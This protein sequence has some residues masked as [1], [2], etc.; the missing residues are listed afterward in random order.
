MHR[1]I[2][3]NTL[4]LAP[5]PFGD[6]VQA[7]A[8]IGA[9]GISPDLEQVKEAGI[10]RAG[11]AIRDAGLEVA[12]LTHRAFGFAT[13]GETTAARQ[14]L[15][16]TI[17]IA[18]EIG[19]QSIIMT[20]GGRGV[21]D[22]T[23]A[24]DRF[25]EA[26]APCAEAARVAGIP[27]GIEPTSHL[28]CDVSIAHRLVDT[29]TLARKAGIGVMID[30][31]ACWV[32]SDITQAIAEACPICPVIQVSDYV[33]GDRGLPCRAVPGDGA[34]PFDQLV[35]AIVQSGFKGWF[36]LEI[37]G[38]RLQAEGQE[39]GLIRA[40]KTTSVMLECFGFPG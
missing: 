9:R 19:A 22:W 16:D 26:M 39:T 5:A 38:P 34:L 37:I 30:L 35:P 15:L 12:T 6:L 14:R 25:A 4:C 10:T 11:R 29:V 8:R 40:A 33:H 24:A 27:L 3:I 36:D 2:S 21:L 28:Y 18:G 32:D 20:T 31:F 23:E 13:S 1:A 17:A 7:V